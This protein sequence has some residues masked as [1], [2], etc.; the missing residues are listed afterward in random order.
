M[1]GRG[2]SPAAVVCF[3]FFPGALRA[4]SSPPGAVPGAGVADL[5]AVA[6]ET[7]PGGRHDVS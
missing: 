6:P 5:A 1:A 3:S 7:S 2:A 4:P